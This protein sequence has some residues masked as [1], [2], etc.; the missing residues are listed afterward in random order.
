[1][2]PS[3]KLD[4]KRFGPFKITKVV[5][6]V[7][8]AFKLELPLQWRIHD[9]FHTTLLDPYHVNEIK[10]RTQLWP[11]LLEIVEGEPEYELKEVLDSKVVGKTV[12]G[13]NATRGSP[14]QPR[15]LGHGSCLFI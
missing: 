15:Q 12:Q 3:A 11:P 5:S 2:P 1:M 4:F 8:L 13:H 7:K 10:G 14:R 9:V 6:E